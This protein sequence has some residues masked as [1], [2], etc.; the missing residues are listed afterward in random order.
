M[1]Q[2]ITELV[3]V[4]AVILLIG[5]GVSF[6]LIGLAIL[7]MMALGDRKKHLV[8]H[9]Q[10]D[11]SHPTSLESR[12]GWRRSQGRRRVAARGGRSERRRRAS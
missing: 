12:H 11:Q 10:T 2:Y 7:M 6:L 5:M 3:G 8:H 9:G 1:D 4:A